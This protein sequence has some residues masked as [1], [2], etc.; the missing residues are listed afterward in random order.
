MR[1]GAK[2]PAPDF[3]AVAQSGADTVVTHQPLLFFEGS[4]SSF[5]IGESLAEVMP[6]EVGEADLSGQPG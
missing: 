5:I 1:R 2:L 3:A 6:A 4:F